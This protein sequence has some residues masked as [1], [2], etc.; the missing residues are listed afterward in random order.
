M[1]RFGVKPSYRHK[2]VN[3]LST[4]ILDPD[5]LLQNDHK[6]KEIVVDFAF[7]KQNQNIFKRK[8][9]SVDMKLSPNNQIE[10]PRK[11]DGFKSDKRHLVLPSVTES[12]S[13]VITKLGMFEVDNTPSKSIFDSSLNKKTREFFK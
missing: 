2:Y 8:K 10:K 12:H 5:C 13:S 7:N 1:K 11:L 9:N 3:G 6:N 4:Q